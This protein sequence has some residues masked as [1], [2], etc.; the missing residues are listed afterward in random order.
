MATAQMDASLLKWLKNNDD[1]AATQS[2]TINSHAQ[3]SPAQGRANTTTTAAQ[4][5]GTD[6]RAALASPSISNSISVAMD[7][8]HSPNVANNAP[9]MSNTESSPALTSATSP[10]VDA[11]ANAANQGGDKA[12]KVDAKDPPTNTMGHC[13]CLAK[14]PPIDCLL[15]R[16][17][18]TRCSCPRRK[19]IN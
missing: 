5:A 15:H 4:R 12:A 8:T 6:T 18:A 2:P 16:W 19:W 13:H 14:A 3:S 10:V 7:K 17:T 11:I 1:G 9:N